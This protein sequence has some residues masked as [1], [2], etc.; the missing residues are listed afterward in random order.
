MTDPNLTPEMTA[1]EVVGDWLRPSPVFPAEPRWGHVNGIQVGLHPLR[2]PRGLLRIYAPYLGHPQDRLVNFIAVEPIV[3]GGTERGFSELEPSS[4]DGVQGKRF[5]SA[6]AP[7]DATP[8][9]SLEP[10]RGVVEQID[11]AD[12]LTVFILA[13]RFESG[14]EVYVRLRFRADRPH[15]V[16]VAGYRRESSAPLDYCVLTAT[17]GNFARLRNLQLA[18]RIVTPAELWP[19]FGGAAFTEHGRFPLAE[20]SRN[21]AGDAI[22][23]ATP[24]ELEPQNAVYADGTAEHWK[25]SGQRAVQSWR[26]ASP[27]RE[28]EVLVNGRFAYWNSESPIPGGTSYENFELVEPFAQGREYFFSVEPLASA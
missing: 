4:L 19:G 1:P 13:E 22:V 8:R 2:G 21:A 16:A 15:E 17:M 3:A 9:A 12:T 24:D 26:A 28:L 14:A 10:A 18:D 7:S 6:D 20:F 5:W 25:Y 11:G 23:S 27:S